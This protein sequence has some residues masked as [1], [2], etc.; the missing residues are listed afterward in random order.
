M[1]KGFLLAIGAIILSSCGTQKAS[2][3]T[4]EERNSTTKSICANA[5][6]L[7]TVEFLTEFGGNK[8]MSIPMEEANP[9]SGKHLV[10]LGKEMPA[11]SSWNWVDLNHDGLKDLVVSESGSVGTSGEATSHVLCQC[12]GNTFVEVMLGEGQSLD[13]LDVAKSEWADILITN[14]SVIS[15]EEAKFEFKYKAYAFDGK[16]YV[17]NTK[18]IQYGGKNWY[19]EDIRTVETDRNAYPKLPNNAEKFKSKLVKDSQ[20]KFQFRLDNGQTKTLTTVPEAEI[21]ENTLNVKFLHFYEDKNLVVFKLTKWEMESYLLVNLANGN[22]VE[23]PSLPE[24]APKGDQF[25]ATQGIEDQPEIESEVSFYTCGEAFQLL[26]NK[27][28]LGTRGFK[29][30]QWASENRLEGLSYEVIGANPTTYREMHIY[31]H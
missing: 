30:L 10:R 26:P 13:V 24:F 8:P 2:I 25:L 11:E 19:F 18:K 12:K 21:Q 28:K 16:Q 15:A 20:K 9:Q 4:S 7:K 1:R 5:E 31:L 14:R 22:E 6:N 3:S 27:I 29:K 23:L 17:A